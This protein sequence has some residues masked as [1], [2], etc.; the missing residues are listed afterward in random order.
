VQKAAII[1]GKAIAQKI[2]LEIAADISKLKSETRK[3]P[4]LAVVLVGSRKDSETYVRSKKKACEEVGITSFGVN[5]PE[6][7]SEDEVL[8]Q[9]QAFNEDPAVHGILVQLPLPKVW[10]F[11]HFITVKEENKSLFSR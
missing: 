11:Y 4:G 7:A 3:V 1:D 9:V 6:D 10:H 8:Q 5:L 2:R